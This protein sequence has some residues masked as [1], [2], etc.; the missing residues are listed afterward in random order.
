MLNKLSP[1][2]RKPVGVIAV[3]FGLF[4][5]SAPKQQPVVFNFDQTINLF[6]P[7]P[8]WPVEKL[9]K[10]AEKQ[11]YE[12]YGKPDYFRIL[13][14]STGE[15]KVRSILEQEWKS[16]GPKNLPPSSWVYLQRNEEIIF[17]NDSFRTQPLTAAVQLIVKMGDPELV[18]DM[19]SGMAQWTY[20]STGKMYTVS[21]GKVA[22]TRSF[23][24]MG[25]Y[26]K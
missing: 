10:P 8:K 25:S 13:W 11:V 17:V 5:F 12:Q 6:Q 14:N 4:P 19:G 7:G 1:F 23:P 2:L 26:H 21:E 16:T 9:L 3:S 22:E 15:I 18:K 20:Y 24:P